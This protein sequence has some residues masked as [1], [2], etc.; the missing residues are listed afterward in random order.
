MLITVYCSKTHAS[1]IQVF[2]QKEQ[3]QNTKTPPPL[4]NI[5]YNSLKGF[6][7]TN[8]MRNIIFIQI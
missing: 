8:L 5:D 6:Y 3:K 7:V 4:E 2:L 1:A